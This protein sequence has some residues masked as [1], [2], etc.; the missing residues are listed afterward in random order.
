MTYRNFVNRKL[1]KTTDFSCELCDCNIFSEYGTVK[2]ISLPDME[3]KYYSF[4][5][6]GVKCDNCGKVYYSDDE[7]T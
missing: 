1:L 7:L 3:K 2:V 4:I 6:Q 5:N